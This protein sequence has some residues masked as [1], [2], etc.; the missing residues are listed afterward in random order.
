MSMPATTPPAVTMTL[1][2]QDPAFEDPVDRL[3]GHAT[4]AVVP[5]FRV[6][7]R[8]P[9]DIVRSQRETRGQAFGLGGVR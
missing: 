5:R 9:C 4:R 8:Q 2:C 1:A 3:E 7:Q 6:E